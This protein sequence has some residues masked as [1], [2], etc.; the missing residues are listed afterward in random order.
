ME[1][2]QTS[3]ELFKILNAN[4]NVLIQSSSEEK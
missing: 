2:W 4:E 1:V 3:S